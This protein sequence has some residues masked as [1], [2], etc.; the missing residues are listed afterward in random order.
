MSN[1]SSTGTYDVAIIGFG[2]VGATLANILG[3]YNISTVILDKEASA[4]HLPRAVAFDDEVLRIFQ[5][6]GLH[7]NMESIA[8]VGGEAH[9]VD[10]NGNLLVRWARPI[11]VS[12]NGWYLNYRFHQPDLERVLGD[13]IKRFSCVAKR[14]NCDVFEL[15]EDADGVTLSCRDQASGEQSKIRARY[16]VGCDGARSFT[17]NAIGSDYEDLGF[18]E[19]W[20]VI[21]LLRNNPEADLGRD[22]RH[23]CDPERSATDVFVGS[24][25]KRWE[26][27]LIEG[28]DPE[29]IT[30][31][32]NVWHLLKRWITPE[33]AT[34]ERAVVYTFRSAIARTWRRGRVLIAGDAAHLTPPFMAQGMCTGIRDTA[35]LGW[36]LER[37]LSGRATGD[38]LDTYPSERKPHVREYIDLTVQMGRL[39]NTT[40][41]TINSGT[42]SDAAGGPQNLS[43]LRPA[44]GPGLA[45]GN[46]K[47]R[48]KLFPQP[49]L[50]SGRRLDDVI[51]YR[52]ALIL[53]PGSALAPNADQ[54]ETL[55]NTE[56]ALIEDGSIALQD[57][58]EEN[59]VEA[60][61]IRPDRYIL[62]T[63]T[64]AEELRAL[65]ANA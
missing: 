16:V 40:A 44:L 9:F 48:G 28:D 21:D 1:S 42:A 33:E 37:V 39:I 51:G 27:R 2:P 64:T 25:R 50:G 34:L 58:F 61:L 29:T 15:D 43:Q 65:I 52:P 30:Q 26:I 10:A 55:R 7:E 4:Y 31:P 19:P 5:S 24:K 11:E 53:R 59:K 63:A 56:I 62:G 3:Q 57:W 35:N 41:A 45:A 49:M 36:K 20:L 12:P 32:D 46:S 13:G 47:G 38:L 60:A 22:S 17:R 23:H 54:K 6:I 14:R 18:E 8:E